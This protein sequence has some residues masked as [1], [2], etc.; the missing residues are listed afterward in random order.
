MISLDKMIERFKVKKENV[1]PF[2]SIDTFNNNNKLEGYICASDGPHYGSMLI[3]KINDVETEQWVLA[4]PKLDYPFDRAKKWHFPSA[5]ELK[6]YNK[7]D[8]SNIVAYGYVFN[9]QKLVTY[10]LRLNP[11]VQ[12]SGRWG[13]FLDMLNELL[14][15]YKD[16][17]VQYVKTHNE[18]LSFE[19]W[20]NRNKHLIVYEQPLDLT[21]LFRIN[22]ITGDILPPVQID[23]IPLCKCYEFA[24]DSNYVQLYKWMQVEDEAKIK[25]TDVGLIGEEGRVWYLKL[26]TG[27]WIMFK[28]KPESVEKIHWAGGL[29]TNIIKATAFNV[30]ETFPEITYERVRDL[31]LE[32]CMLKNIEDKKEFI[33]RIINEV[34]EQLVFE[35]QVLDEYKKVGKS[36]L[37][38][39]VTVM[40][41]LSKRFPSNK[42]SHVYA[43]ISV[44]RPV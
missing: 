29:G 20:G 16:S 6:I 41:A 39:K 31:L 9:G 37:E 13:P 10:K 43:V 7:L 2:A 19:L 1:K 35:Q 30:L 4:T 42:M 26:S 3:T 11:I 28:M 38:D 36:I 27:K 33:I 32:T 8:G 18:N 44:G 23:K 17:I 14:S 12:N 24:K 22:A 21:L 15:K 34:N 25:K 40:R 5:L